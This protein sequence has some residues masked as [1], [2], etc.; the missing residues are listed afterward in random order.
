MLRH[1]QK[2][3]FFFS[4]LTSFLV[5]MRVYTHSRTNPVPPWATLFTPARTQAASR[6]R[7]SASARQQYQKKAGN[8]IAR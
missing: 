4:P 7:F 2:N 8:L 1:W 6:V 5:R 3:K